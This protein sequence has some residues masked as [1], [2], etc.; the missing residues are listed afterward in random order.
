MIFIRNILFVILFL[1]LTSCAHEKVVI[2][3]D[4]KKAFLVDCSDA[5]ANWKSCYEKIGSLCSTKG[6]E[7]IE[8]S[9]D[10]NLVR[11]GKSDTRRILA[12]CKE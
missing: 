5:F 11:N 12:R 10:G 4:G 7:I 8:S 1:F 3:Q 9:L 6:Y 2:T